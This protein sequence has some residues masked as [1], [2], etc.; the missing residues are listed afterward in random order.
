MTLTF[1]KEVAERMVAT[2]W[3]EVKHKFTIPGKAFLPK[4]DVDVGVVTLVPLKDPLVKLPFDMV[5]RVIRHVFNMRQKASHRGGS[6]LFPPELRNELGMNVKFTIP[7]KAFLPKP[8]VDVGVVTLVPLKDPL[9]KLPFD[10]VE[11]VIRH[12]FNMRQK[13]SHRGGSCLFPPELRNELG[14]KLFCIADTNYNARP[15][16]LTTEE[17][18]RLCYAYASLCKEYPEI[19][20]YD[21]RSPKK[22]DFAVDI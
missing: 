2:L 15:F 11:R 7:G 10:M 8:D 16:E 20:N 9:V 13:A 18:A 6:C 19:E 4:P 3:G 5:E 14:M 22:K 12:V 1:Q 17:F 21:F